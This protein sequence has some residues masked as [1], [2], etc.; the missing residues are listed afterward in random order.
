M[1]NSTGSN[2]LSDAFDLKYLSSDL[3]INISEN[4]KKKYTVQQMKQIYV[5]VSLQGAIKGELKR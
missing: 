4:R 5:R 3:K 1:H 2:G